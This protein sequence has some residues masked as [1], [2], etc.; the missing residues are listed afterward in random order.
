[1]S[2][3]LESSILHVDLTTHT[4]SKRI[5]SDSDF[6]HFLG[7]RGLAAKQL[8]EGQPKGVDAFDPRNQIIFATGK[9]VGTPVPTAGQ[10]TV[11][12]KSPATGMYFK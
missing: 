1:M 4:I 5:A 10:V 11:T 12:S 7:G 9:L 3:F 8:F 2:R 6:Y